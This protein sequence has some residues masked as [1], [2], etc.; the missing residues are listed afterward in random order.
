MGILS[1]TVEEKEDEIIKKYSD[2]LEEQ[3]RAKIKRNLHW[4]KSDR[5]NKMNDQ[6]QIGNHTASIET[7]SKKKKDL[8]DVIKKT[9]EVQKRGKQGLEKR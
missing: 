7:I 4:I 5:K 2:N 1:T 6:S 3:N 8:L 9:E